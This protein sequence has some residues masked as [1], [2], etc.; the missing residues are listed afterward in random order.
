MI[1]E[2]VSSAI[3]VSFHCRRSTA[4][5][6]GAVARKPPRGALTPRSTT[7]GGP[8]KHNPRLGPARGPKILQQICSEQVIDLWCKRLNSFSFNLKF[9]TPATPLQDTHPNR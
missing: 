2:P 6:I 4:D 9:L 1:S 3:A 8:A 5:H 7:N